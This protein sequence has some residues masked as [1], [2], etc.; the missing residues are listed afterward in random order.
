M[1][2]KCHILI[3]F[4]DPTTNRTTRVV[5]F[6]KKRKGKQVPNMVSST[7]KQ[8]LWTEWKQGNCLISIDCFFCLTTLPRLMRRL[9]TPEF[10][11]VCFPSGNNLSDE[12][13]ESLRAAAS[14]RSN[15]I[16]IHLWSFNVSFVT[17]LS[18]WAQSNKH[19]FHSNRFCLELALFGLLF[20][21]PHGF[22]VK[23][24]AF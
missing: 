10:C 9:S 16:D 12:I 24:F 19:T 5:V 22:D 13:K 1:F 8:C 7:W 3:H 15:R 20:P 18:F 23:I 6:L 4:A 11:L 14:E 21:S 2:R 17:S